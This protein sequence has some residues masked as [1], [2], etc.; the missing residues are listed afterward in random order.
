LKL[1]TTMLLEV[2]LAGPGEFRTFI[3]EQ[4]AKWRPVKN[5]LQYV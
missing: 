1:T 2:T 4:V 3:H 5:N